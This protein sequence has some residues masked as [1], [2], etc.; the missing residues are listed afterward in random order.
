MAFADADFRRRVV[1]KVEEVIRADVCSGCAHSASCEKP[2]HEA[3]MFGRKH[4]WR[5]T[6]ELTRWN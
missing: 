2:C 5:L 4:L 6:R 1:M 3:V